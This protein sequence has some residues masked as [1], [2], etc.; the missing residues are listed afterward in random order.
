VIPD[1]KQHMNGERKVSIVA[2]R[3]N[4]Q[5]QIWQRIGKKDQH[6]LDCEMAATGFMMMRGHIKVK[7]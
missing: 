2:G 3:D 5:R 4:Q 6:L 1:F 7:E